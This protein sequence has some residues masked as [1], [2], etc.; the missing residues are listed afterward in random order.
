[1]RSLLFLSIALLSR[2]G[3]STVAP[4][5]VTAPDSMTARVQLFGA[6]EWHANVIVVSNGVA[7]RYM[8]PVYDRSEFDIGKLATGSTFT[9]RTGAGGMYEYFKAPDSIRVIVGQDTVVTY[10]PE[11]MEA[12]YTVPLSKGSRK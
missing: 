3:V 8:K 7:A 9:M 6:K 2:C 4:E 12:V 5:L 1:M 11:G 10:W